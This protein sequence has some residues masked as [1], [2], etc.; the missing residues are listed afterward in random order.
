MTAPDGRRQAGGRHR[1][2]GAGSPV[3]TAA[4]PLPIHATQPCRYQG[5]VSAPTWHL[6]HTL[7]A[8]VE[9]RLHSLSCG[10]DRQMRLLPGATGRHARAQQRHLL[11]LVHQPPTYASA[12]SLATPARLLLD[13]QAKTNARCRLPCAPGPP[14]LPIPQ[15][16]TPPTH[17]A[18]D[19]FAGGRVQGGA[20]VVVATLGAA[21]RGVAACQAAQAQL[22]ATPSSSILL[23]G[24]GNR[25]GRA[26]RA[27]GPDTKLRIAG[28]PGRQGRGGQAAGRALTRR[29]TR[30][31]RGCWY[32]CGL[33]QSMGRAAH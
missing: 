25:E 6:M 19:A 5:P 26:K 27:A 4:V 10:A 30:C 17:L 3:Q 20:S 16:P 13:V 11:N 18:L 15:P 1:S 9:H 24:S 12:W 14:H 7:G 32:T 28:Q 31:R 23:A 22:S 21:T 2:P 8:E 33:A 29:C